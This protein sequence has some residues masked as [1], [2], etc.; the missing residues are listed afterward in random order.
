MSMWS[1]ILFKRQ[2]N[3]CWRTPTTTIFADLTARPNPG[4]SRFERTGRPGRLAAG[5]RSEH[6]QPPPQPQ[7]SQPKAR[8]RTQPRED[9]RILI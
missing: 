9:I 2:R 1:N 3:L 8:T 7:T 6:A 5:A 4:R